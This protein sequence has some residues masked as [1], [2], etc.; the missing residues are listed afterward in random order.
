MTAGRFTRE[1]P[2]AVALMAVLLA[3]LAASASYIAAPA[4]VRQSIP[5]ANPSYYATL[6]LAVTFPFNVIVGIPLYYQITRV[7]T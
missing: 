1:I 4:A 7:F 6:P 3:V 2:P 5:Q